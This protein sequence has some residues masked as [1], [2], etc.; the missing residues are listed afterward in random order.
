MDDLFI[1]ISICNLRLPTW[2]FEAEGGYWWIL[3]IINIARLQ[4]LKVN[5]MIS[6]SELCCS[7][8]EKPLIHKL[9]NQQEMKSRYAPGC[10]LFPLVDAPWWSQTWLHEPCNS[11]V[12][13]RSILQNHWKLVRQSSKSPTLMR[14][15]TRGITTTHPGDHRWPQVLTV[16]KCRV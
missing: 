5:M 6:D 1:F 3:S 12:P 15:Q 4:F 9:V 14:T 16:G 10:Q 2:V 13:C 7:L 11:Y 8:F